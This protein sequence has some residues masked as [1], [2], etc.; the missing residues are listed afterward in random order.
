MLRIIEYA[1]YDP[2][3]ARAFHEALLIEMLDLNTT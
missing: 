3:R 2:P 1:L